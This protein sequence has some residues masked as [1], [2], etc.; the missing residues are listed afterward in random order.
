[1]KATV[2]YK[3]GMFEVNKALFDEMEDK[4]Y[5]MSSKYFNY[6]LSAYWDEDCIHF[7][8]DGPWEC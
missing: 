6:V 2:W 1:M 3:E 8:A 5:E 7:Y 4:I